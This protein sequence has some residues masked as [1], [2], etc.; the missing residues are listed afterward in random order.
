MNANT[1]EK[2]T[3]GDK[4]P[5][6]QSAYLRTLFEEDYF[7]C[8]TIGL[9][10]S[11]ENLTKQS[12]LCIALERAQKAESELAEVKEA[13]RSEANWHETFEQCYED[14]KAKNAKLRGILESAIADHD[15]RFKV[16]GALMWN[17]ITDMGSDF[18]GDEWSESVLPLAQKAGLAEQVEYNPEIHG[19][20]E[21][22]RG[23]TIWYWGE[24]LNQNGL[25]EEIGNETVY[26]CQLIA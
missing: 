25:V 3:T 17:Y 23:D 8:G 2:P 13:L 12:P 18:T 11:F 20:V 5:H 15:E 6:C 21:A 7:S 4:C 1:P 10:G 16:F 9:S 26:K 14:E 24:N 19:H 22:E